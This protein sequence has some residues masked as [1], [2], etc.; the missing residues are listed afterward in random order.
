MSNTAEPNMFQDIITNNNDSLATFAAIRLLS[1]CWTTIPG[2][3][4]AYNHLPANNMISALDMQLRYS[5][6]ENL[7]SSNQSDTTSQYRA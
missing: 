5:P 1:C 6:S 2:I 4:L 3:D 7:I